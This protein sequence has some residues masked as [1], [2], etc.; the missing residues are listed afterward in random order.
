MPPDKIVI[1]DNAGVEKKSVVGPYLEG[2]V[3]TVSCE[4]Y[5]GMYLLSTINIFRCNIFKKR[6]LYVSRKSV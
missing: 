1:R 3:V 4:V 2:D 5:G 6:T